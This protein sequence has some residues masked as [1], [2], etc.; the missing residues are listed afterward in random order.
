MLVRDYTPVYSPLGRYAG[1]RMEAYGD[2]DIG[3]IIAGIGGAV[4]DTIGAVTNA[5]T[6]GLAKASGGTTSTNQP[7]VSP[8]G[9]YQPQ[10]QQQQAAGPQKS[11]FSDP[12]VLGAAGLAVLGLGAVLLGRRRGRMAGFAGLF[13][14]HSRRRRSRRHGRR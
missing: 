7:Y 12:L 8:I 13:A 11:M 10:Q 9:T 2:V 6:A 3:G 1:R 5:Y 4:K 14:G